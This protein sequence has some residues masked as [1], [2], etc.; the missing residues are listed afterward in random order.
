MSYLNRLTDQLVQKH[1]TCNIFLTLKLQCVAK[2]QNDK[3]YCSD[4]L[5]RCGWIFG[6]LKINYRAGMQKKEIKL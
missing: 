1:L 4:A 6:C 2:I 5:E 3:V